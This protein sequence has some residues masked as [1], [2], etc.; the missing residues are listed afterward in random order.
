MK[1]EYYI[2]VVDKRVDLDPPYVWQSEPF[3]TKEEALLQTVRFAT[4]MVAKRTVCNKRRSFE[5]W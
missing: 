3:A 1:Q 4:H 2:E 5:T